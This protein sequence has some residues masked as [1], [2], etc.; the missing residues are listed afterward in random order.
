M[1]FSQRLVPWLYARKI[2]LSEDTLKWFSL[3]G[4]AA[5][6]SLMVENI[7][8]FSPAEILALAVALA[9]SIKSRNLGLTVLSAVLIGIFALLL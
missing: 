6:A 9:V 1:T 5:F 8:A 7:S 3:V 2:R 4:T